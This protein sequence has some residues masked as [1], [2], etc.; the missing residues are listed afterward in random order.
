MHNRS[1]RF[2][3]GN[4]VYIVFVAWE[5]SEYCNWKYS[6][7]SFG[8]RYFVYRCY[9]FFQNCCKVDCGS[10]ISGNMGKS[11]IEIKKSLQTIWKTEKKVS[12]LEKREVKLKN[13][14]LLE[15]RATFYRW[16]RSK[17]K[18]NKMRTKSDKMRTE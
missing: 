6:K 18:W 9:C 2:T 17:D 11:G 4:S 5:K 10:K 16:K 7:G 13:I 12:F 3:V 15:C 8:K 1:Y 14:S